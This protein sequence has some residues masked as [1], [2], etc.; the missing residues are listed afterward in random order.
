MKTKIAPS[1]LL[2]V[3]SCTN[4]EVVAFS[5][6]RPSATTSH[7]HPVSLSV[8]ND[9]DTHYNVDVDRRGNIEDISATKL[10]RRDALARFAATAV[11]SATFL[12]GEAAFAAGADATEFSESPTS[13]ASLARMAYDGKTIPAKEEP[14]SK[15]AE[16]AVAPKAEAKKPSEDFDGNE[17]GPVGA[18][19]EGS[20]PPSTPMKAVSATSF[21]NSLPILQLP[22]AYDDPKVIAAA[23]TILGVSALGI[24]GESEEEVATTSAPVAKSAPPAQPYGLSGGR[25]YWDGVDMTA[26]KNAGLVAKKAPPPP[27]PTAP[28]P[29]KPAA[30]AVQVEEQK[31]K[32]KWQ[33]DTPVPY[34]IQNKDG[35]NPFVKQ[36]QE[37]CVGGKVTE[38][39]AKTIKVYLDDLADTGAVATSGEV[40]AIVGYLDSLGSN[41]SNPENKRA[42][43][44]FTSY[45]DALSAGSA[46]PPSSAKAVKTYLD[47]L[48]EPG[49]SAAKSTQREPMASP[50]VEA[51]PIESAPAVVPEPVALP[52]AD[53]S[54]YDVRLTSI[55]GR[56]DSLETK[57]D[58]LPDKVFEKIEAW[59]TQQEAR[60]GDEV[61][62]IVQALTPPP[63]PP[64]PEPA[65]APVPEP[66]AVV[67]EPPV[68]IP[69]P[70]PAPIVSATPLAGA[71]PPRGMP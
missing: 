61:K 13:E 16:E 44:A 23:V 8:S 58:Q 14:V 19:D 11:G 7:R 28:E 2:S 62:K 10:S 35:K 24:N 9:F 69:E 39:C 66:V 50:N 49:S 15:P 27:P 63:A 18:T 54:E 33:L 51:A 55:E 70:E 31:E 43:A 30:P 41:N 64:A 12:G 71:I 17:A 3:L 36:V 45:L 1:V 5:A 26:A 20:Q 57:V 40:K 29:V 52:T 67:K 4:D 38:D 34:G 65:T 42:G 37:Y 53:F 47:T 48:V 22:S 25:N 68:S 32:P 56:V 60:L 46:P 6:V 59:Q 21:K